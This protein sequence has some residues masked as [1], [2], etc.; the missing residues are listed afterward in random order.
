MKR[1]EFISSM[2]KP[3]HTKFQ[4]PRSNNYSYL[5]L[6]LFLDHMLLLEY[7]YFLI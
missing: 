5:Y 2:E 4:L 1:G 6:D 3:L 7:P